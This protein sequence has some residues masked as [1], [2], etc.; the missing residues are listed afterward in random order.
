MIAEAGF[1]RE[2][3]T[4]FKAVSGSITIPMVKNGVTVNLTLPCQKIE[5]SYL[6]DPVDFSCTDEV[7]KI[8]L[9]G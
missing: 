7:L 3:V 5:V 9:R 4:L 8:S 1:T 2:R 6:S